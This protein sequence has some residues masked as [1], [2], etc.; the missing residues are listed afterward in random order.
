MATRKTTQLRVS[1][2]CRARLEALRD[3]MPAAGRTAGEIAEILSLATPDDL[4]SIFT[5]AAARGRE[6]GGDDAGA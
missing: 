5:A 2:E 1:P 6:D 3:T 4:V